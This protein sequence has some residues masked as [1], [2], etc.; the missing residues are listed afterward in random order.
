MNDN[1]L[2]STQTTSALAC[3]LRSSQR[4][5]QRALRQLEEA[6]AVRAVGHGRW[7]RWRSPA[8]GKF[9]TALLLPGVLSVGWWCIIKITRKSKPR[10]AEILRECGPYPGID[11]IHGVTF[12]AAQVCFPR[13]EHR[14]AR[15]QERRWFA[16]SVLH[17]GHL[18][19][20]QW[21]SDR[22]SGYAR[23]VG[24]DLRSGA[25]KWVLNGTPAG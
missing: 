15:F 13:R 14:R 21:R 2:T 23:M 3:A 7:R 18:Q 10:E 24:Y 19:H 25:H 1:L 11:H 22:G 5:V 16:S 20:T 17:A 6:A 4:S 12:N 8:L 9:A